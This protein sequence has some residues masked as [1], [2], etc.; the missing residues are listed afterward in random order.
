MLCAIG[1]TLF[2]FTCDAAV[3]IGRDDVARHRHCS[4]Y[5]G[6]HSSGVKVAVWGLG[7][8]QLVFFSSS[9]HMR[10]RVRFII[11]ANQL[12]SDCDACG[13]CQSLLHLSGMA[14]QLQASWAVLFHSLSLPVSMALC[15]WGI[16]RSNRLP[17]PLP[18]L[19]AHLTPPPPLPDLH[20]HPSF[21]LHPHLPLAFAPPSAAASASREPAA[22]CA[23]C[24]AAGGTAGAGRAMRRR[25]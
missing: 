9:P 24:R 20:L 8:L 22:C 3:S 18:P 2:R 21:Q 11:R 7:V 16:Q 1:V 4:C 6:A 10:L 23:T 12:S 14:L 15:V 5:D 13:T 25:R 17:P 19:L